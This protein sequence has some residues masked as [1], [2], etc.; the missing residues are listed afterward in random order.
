MAAS[1]TFDANEMDDG[2]TND[3]SGGMNRVRKY[4]CELL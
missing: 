1:S 4:S 2:A 3:Y